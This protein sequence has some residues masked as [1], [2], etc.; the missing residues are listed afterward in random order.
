MLRLPDRQLAADVVQA[1]C[2]Q[3]L[4]QERLRCLQIVREKSPKTPDRFLLWLHE[5]R[6]PLL[7]QHGHLD[8]A[9]KVT[10][11]IEALRLP[12]PALSDALQTEFRGYLQR[13]RLRYKFHPV[14]LLPHDSVSWGEL[15]CNTL[16]RGLDHIAR[17]TFNVD[18]VLLAF[19]LLCITDRDV[20]EAPRRWSECYP[21]PEGVTRNLDR[22]RK[23]TLE[24]LHGMHERLRL[25]NAMTESIATGNKEMQRLRTAMR[26]TAHL[27]DCLA[28]RMEEE[29]RHRAQDQRNAR[30][31][32]VDAL[33]TLADHDTLRE[34]CDEKEVEAGFPQLR[35]MHAQARS[36]EDRAV[37]Y[38][39]LPGDDPRMPR[40]AYREMVA[41]HHTL[42][43]I[44]LMMRCQSDA[45]TDAPLPEIEEDNLV[46]VEDMIRQRSEETAIFTAGEGI[47]PAI[48]NAP[49][50]TYETL[51]AHIKQ[52]RHD[53]QTAPQKAVDLSQSPFVKWCR[54]AQDCLRTLQQRQEDGLDHLQQRLKQYKKDRDQARQQWTAQVKRRSQT[55]AHTFPF[56]SHRFKLNAEVVSRRR[57]RRCL[58][59][60]L[61]LILVHRCNYCDN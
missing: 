50:A 11:L 34:A 15:R 49:A 12:F 58:D 28:E 26:A 9:A 21:V 60:V 40:R 51:I 3:V 52:A 27:R 18:A 47:L 44:R 46:D 20:Q 19:P 31:A 25:F 33:Q 38:R 56:Y 17:P 48:Q 45:A 61:V 30:Q 4:K 1:L 39:A 23:T 14:P 43:D 32:L 55:C 35:R 10:E 37:A 59:H 53:I 36:L 7:D 41:L 57:R 6:N 16:T 2:D 29:A 24:L 5:N 54:L 8:P 13:L 22:W 42:Q